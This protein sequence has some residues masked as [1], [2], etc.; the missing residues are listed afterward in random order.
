VAY[1]QGALSNL[2]NPKIAVFFTSLLPQFGGT[3]FAAL[4]ALGLIFCALTLAWL[5]AYAVVVARAGDVL[6]RPA[7]RRAIDAT[8]GLV[9]V[10][11]GL[12]LATER[13]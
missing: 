9:L 11:F 6:R 7:V 3:S 13:R 5:A 8:V 12:R 10:A 1:R 2:G 4:F